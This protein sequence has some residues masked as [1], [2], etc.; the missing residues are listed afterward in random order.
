MIFSFK[1]Y[2]VTN[3]GVLSIRCACFTLFTVLTFYDVIMCYDVIRFLASV[4]NH[5]I[6]T[7]CMKHVLLPRNKFQNQLTLYSRTLLYKN[8]FIHRE[9]HRFFLAFKGK[10]LLKKKTG[11]AVIRRSCFVC[12]FCSF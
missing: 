8:I 10:F 1:S 2:D 3:S 5:L 11:S 7:N 12:I 4:H 9:L 6:I